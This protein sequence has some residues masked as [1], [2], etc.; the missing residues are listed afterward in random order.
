MFSRKKAQKSQSDCFCVFCASLWLNFFLKHLPAVFETLKHIEARTC[1][2]EQT[3]H[4]LSPP[5]PQT[6]AR[7]HPSYPTRAQTA[8]S[9]P[10]SFAIVSAS[11]P[12]STSFLTFVTNQRLER[13]VRRFLPSATENQHDLPGLCRERFERLQR[14]INARRFRVVVKLHALDLSHK[15]QPV[16]DRIESLR[17]ARSS[18]RST[19]PPRFPL[20]T[21][22]RRSRRCASHATSSRQRLT[23]PVSRKINSRPRRKTPFSTSFLTLKLNTFARKPLAHDE[24][25]GSSALSTAVSSAVWF[26]KIRCF[27]AA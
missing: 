16:L 15:L 3:P 26:M 1:R 18:I 24:T 2:R 21:L 5:Q 11:S 25:V 23:A 14:R 7:P 20:Q 19:R 22:P 17:R 27:A 9:L 10:N 8:R 4:R 6:N 13:R 12:M